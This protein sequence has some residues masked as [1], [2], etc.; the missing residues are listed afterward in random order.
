[1]S[2]VVDAAVELKGAAG[3]VGAAGHTHDLILADLDFI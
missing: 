2:G 1:L 3:K